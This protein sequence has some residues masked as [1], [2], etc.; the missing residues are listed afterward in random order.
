MPQEIEIFAAG[1]HTSSNGATVTLSESDLDAIA[2]SY[3]P[4]LFD[5]PAVVGHPRDN[6]PA[7]AWVEGVRRVGNKL[8]ASLKDWDADFQEAVKSRRY[9]KISASFYSPDSSSNPK[10][11]SYYL[12]HVGFLG[13]MAPAVKGLKSVAFAEAEEGVVDFC[14]GVGGD[15]EIFRNLR[16]WLIEEY[17]IEVSDRVV[18]AYLLSMP[19]DGR[20]DYLE[21][22]VDELENFI[23]KTFSPDMESR[24]EEVGE[25][26]LQL[27]NKYDYTE[28]SEPVPSQESIELSEEVGQL[29]AEL[30]QAKLEKKREN[31][32][33][34]VESLK[35]KIRPNQKGQLV[36]FMMN[37]PEEEVEFSEG[38]PQTHLTWLQNF[39]KSQPD[40][41]N[42]KEVVRDENIEAFSEEE[43]QSR[44]AYAN[45]AKA[46]E[47]AWK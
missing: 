27:L 10:P 43:K 40:L 15:K 19:S 2:Q 44:S 5:A 26:V 11:G 33:N 13:G 22:R 28:E 23:S 38:K 30:R 31:V 35:G 16:E 39:L 1:T 41:V 34:F 7:Y 18:P 29:K 37:L 47:E 4:D 46:Y 17:G 32:A 9:K 45:A 42:L 14:C 20:L 8:M 25:R 24:L 6:S 12:R 21:S 36:E 3:D